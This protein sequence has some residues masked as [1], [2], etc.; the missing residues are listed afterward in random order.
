MTPIERATFLLHAE[1]EDYRARIQAARHFITEA[2]ERAEKPYISY[3]GGKDSLVMLHMA[4]QAFPEV[5][6]WHWDY[7]SHYMPR[8]LEAEILKNAHETGARNIHVDT[9]KKYD[10][11]RSPKNILFPALFGY[12]QP[13]MI[14]DGYDMVCIGL[15]AEESKRRKAKTASGYREGK[16]RECYPVYQ[17]TTSD[18]WAYIVT[19]NLPYC[20]HYD[21][22]G[23]LLGIEQVRM[24]TF[25]DPEFDK[26]GAGNLDGILM[27]KFKHPTS[28]Q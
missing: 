12:I 6:V 22:Y 2:L 21:R 15:R 25:F 20:S 24:S 14:S 18:I 16:L 26:F 27:T 8:E 10:A 1:L 7:G 11:G 17:L 3:S 5:L 28:L 9:S 23:A 19:N 4:L 13:R